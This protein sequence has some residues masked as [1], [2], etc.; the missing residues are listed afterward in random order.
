MAEFFDSLSGSERNVLADDDGQP[1]TRSIVGRASACVDSVQLV[2]QFVAGRAFAPPIRR[3]V[4]GAV[5]LPILAGS[6]WRRLSDAFT[7][8][9]LSASDRGGEF[10]GR[11]G[12]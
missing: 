10:D 6:V 12:R 1:A 9:D 7:Q 5:Q 3:T 4:S 2:R 11:R 8:R